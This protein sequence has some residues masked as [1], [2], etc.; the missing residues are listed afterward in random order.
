MKNH[1][2]TANQ[3]IKADLKAAGFEVAENMDGGTLIS[4]NRPVSLMEVKMALY[5]EGYE[6]SQ[7]KG[8]L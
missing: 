2:R 4:L 1:K 7:F 8:R 3:M 5:Q 6:D